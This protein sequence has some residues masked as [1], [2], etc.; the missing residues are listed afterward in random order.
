[1]RVSAVLAALILVSGAACSSETTASVTLSVAGAAS[2]S[3]VNVSVFDERRAATLDYRLATPQLPGTFTARLPS[4]ASQFRIAVTAEGGLL[5]A[6]S[7]RAVAG[8]QVVAPPIVLRPAGSDAEH[9][10]P[11]GDGVA[12]PIDDCPDVANH[13]Q[14]DADGDG[15]GDACATGGPDGGPSGD[16]GPPPSACPGSFLFCDGFEEGAI[17]PTRWP[18]ALRSTNGGTTAVDSTRSF[19]GGASLKVTA[20]PS[21]GG[22]FMSVA[23]TETAAVPVFP[24]YVRLYLYVPTSLAARGPT[25]LV[26]SDTNLQ[27]I[28]V[29]SRQGLLG[30]N[31]NLAPADT[32]DST[33]SLGFGRWSCVELGFEPSGGNTAMRLYAS[34][35]NPVLEYTLTGAP[36]LGSVAI[37]YQETLPAS[38]PGGEIWID[39]IVVDRARI[40]CAR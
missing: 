27:P 33:T 24:L 5:G 1:M 20:S 38:F 15:T 19:R 3:A 31:V 36:R 4:R 16:G 6:T 22:G 30:V 34:D 39:E 32:I 7:V 8:G 25:F 28:N 37:G 14:E 12:T 18:I 29:Y 11:D 10:D 2:P 21:S 17:D 9:A 23:L 40:G 35:G 13:A 26:V